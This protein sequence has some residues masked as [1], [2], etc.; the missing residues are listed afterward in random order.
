[1]CLNY[2]TFS[3]LNKKSQ[4]QNLYRTLIEDLT[5]Q[6]FVESTWEIL[7]QNRHDN[8]F[9]ENGFRRSSSHRGSSTGPGPR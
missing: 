2:E 6:L 8:S 1:M 3:R 9:R 5:H 7:Q 4:F